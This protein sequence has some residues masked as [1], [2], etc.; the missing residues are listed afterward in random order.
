MSIPLLTHFAPALGMID[1]PGSRKVHL[2]AV[3]RSG[4]L[5]LALGLAAALVL[6]YDRLSHFLLGLVGGLVIILLFGMADD[7][8]GLTAWQK[9][10]GQAL[11][12]AAAVAG[13]VRINTLGSIMGGSALAL[14]PWAAPVSIIF[15]MAATNAINLAD[16]LDGLAGGFSLLIFTF[17]ALLAASSQQTGLMLF[18]VSMAGAALGFLRYN[19]YPA[20]IFL[21]DAGSQ[22]LG[23]S[24][25]LAAVML[26]QPPSPYSPML[27]LMM[28][29]LPLL[30][31]VSVAF[32]R[33]SEGGSPFRADRRHLHH[34]LL[35][36]G[37]SHQE[38][39]LTLYIF[40]EAY[41]GLAYVLRGY[42]GG[43][44]LCGY[45][46]LCLGAW[47]FTRS[48]R[49]GGHA[50]GPE[51]RPLF[52]T[53]RKVL[54]RRRIG[55]A[56]HGLLLVAITVF[57]LA[58]PLAGGAG[59]DAGVISVLLLA[60]LALARNRL[61]YLMPHVLRLSCYFLGGYLIVFASESPPGLVGRLSLDWA[62]LRSLY[63][64]ALIGLLLIYAVGTRGKPL[65]STLDA[66]A[67]VAALLLPLGPVEALHDHRFLLGLSQA[68]VFFVCLEPYINQLRHRTAFARVPIVF[69]LAVSGLGAWG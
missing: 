23:F 20:T 32:E 54:L 8:R 16:G 18:S 68:V 34:R 48:L 41:I 45:L 7:R 66:L 38:A 44:I 55:E 2:R 58:M 1:L 59:R 14:G 43:Y 11:A 40:Q 13:G 6:T 35:G 10:A 67:L 31:S 5:G 62:L 33:L 27:S 4:G 51:R 53:L 47:L 24:A 29:G 12:A 49:G 21:G 19:T 17:I 26:T 52:E 63:F 39:V 22:I 37:L 42:Q 28:L 69:G 57:F 46:G 9:M 56:A 60:A 15:L 64:A 36:C 30:D 65:L 3:P 50:D 61:G 25:G